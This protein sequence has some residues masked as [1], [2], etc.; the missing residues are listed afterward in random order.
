MCIRDSIKIYANDAHSYRDLPVRLA[1]FGTVYRWEPVSYTHL[2][3]YKRQVRIPEDQE[4]LPVFRGHRAA[5]EV[6]QRGDVYKR[7]S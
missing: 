2:D 6:A 3:V 7:Q 5:L 1:E 4:R